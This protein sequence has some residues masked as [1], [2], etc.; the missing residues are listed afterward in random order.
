AD[1]RLDRGAPDR[2][3]R[4]GRS[5]TDGAHAARTSGR[6]RFRP[7]GAPAARASGR[8]RLRPPAR[9]WPRRPRRRVALLGWGGSRA[10]RGLLVVHATAYPAFPFLRAYRR[11]NTAQTMSWIWW[12]TIRGR[13]SA[14][15]PC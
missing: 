13:S 11:A 10:Y 1:P 12:K 4:P 5:G 8:A 14:P 6:A 9:G 3:R 15:T 7:R 2:S